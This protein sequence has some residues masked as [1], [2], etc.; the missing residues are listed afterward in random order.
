MCLQ[1]WIL[2]S[3]WPSDCIHCNMTKS[4]NN[5]PLSVCCV[6]CSASCGKFICRKGSDV[7]A[8]S[9]GGTDQGG[10]ETHP[11]CH[12][13]CHERHPWFACWWKLGLALGN[14]QVN[15]FLWIY[16]QTLINVQSCGCVQAII[17]CD[18]NNHFC[19][20]EPL[21][22]CTINFWGES[23]LLS[24]VLQVHAQQPVPCDM[25]LNFM[26]EGDP[27]NVRPADEEDAAPAWPGGVRP[28]YQNVAAFA[29]GT[30]D[31]SGMA[32]MNKEKHLISYLRQSC[33]KGVLY[34]PIWEAGKGLGSFWA[35][36]HRNG[37][38]A[39][40]KSKLEWL[41]CWMAAL[42]RKEL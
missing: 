36:V 14:F 30:S 10:P 37:L 42:W 25:L 1:K 2:K 13:F 9:N 4:G 19:A 11:G 28:W 6:W 8:R 7:L 20:Q 35:L 16:I 40:D 33:S 22:N 32:T 5:L 34:Q 17:L 31:G 24:Q 26:E 23:T 29:N 27:I 3:W 39:L 15:I 41:S 12:F 38:P 21:T 18:T